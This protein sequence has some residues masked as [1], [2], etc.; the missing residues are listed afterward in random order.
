M[1]S[2]TEK[3]QQ[4]DQLG[5]AGV[6]SNVHFTG[7]GFNFADLFGGGFGDI[8]GDLF[9]GGRHAG[10]SRGACSSSGRGCRAELHIKLE[11]TVL[12]YEKEVQYRRAVPMLHV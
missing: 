7:E 9:G 12:E 11:D 10:G 5:F 8:F 2:D 1:L 6:E 4:Y 3:R